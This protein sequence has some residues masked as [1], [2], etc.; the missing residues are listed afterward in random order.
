[1]CDVHGGVID[2]IEE[3]IIKK[4]LK[5]KEDK[6]LTFEEIG[7]KLQKNKVWVASLFFR[8]ATA[9]KDEAE[10]LGKILDLDNDTIKAIQKPPI[11]GDLIESIPSDPLIYR[12]YEIVRV[13][14]IP[15]KSIINE[16]FGDGIMSAI[17]LSIDVKKDEKPDEER[18]IITLN[19]KFLPYKRW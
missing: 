4:L 12:L 10:E 8:Q 13:Y 14:G 17:D 7:K 16:M 9:S 2:M 1:M 5:A 15:L 3:P 19:G 6:H 18:V 11:R